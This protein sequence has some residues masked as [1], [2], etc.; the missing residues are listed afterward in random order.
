MAI[1]QAE[2]R[3]ALL[4]VPEAAARCRLSVRQMWRHVEQG[5]LKVVRLGRAVRIRPA[6]L[7][8]FID[9]EWE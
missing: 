6:E 7:Y 5:H 9:G 4:T 3:E 1:R 2:Q 8:R